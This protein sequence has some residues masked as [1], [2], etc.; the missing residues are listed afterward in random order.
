MRDPATRTLLTLRA[1]RA[2][3]SADV[4]LFDDRV[5]PAVLEFARREAKKMLV[6]SDQ[7]SLAIG[8]AQAG[9]R[10]VRLVS[11]DAVNVCRQRSRDHSVDVA[12]QHVIGGRRAERIK[13]GRR[14]LSPRGSAP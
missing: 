6:G 9:R 12:R 11:G 2:L 1:V 10:V 4:I 8:L 3:Q 14:R 5:S 13:P 7:G